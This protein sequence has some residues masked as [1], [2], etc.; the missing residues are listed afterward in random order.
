MEK[1]KELSLIT[2]ASYS[3]L[4]VSREQRKRQNAKVNLNL[5]SGDSRIITAMNDIWTQQSM[6]CYSYYFMYLI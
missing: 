6:K 4:K 1:G 3:L 2:D 5:Y